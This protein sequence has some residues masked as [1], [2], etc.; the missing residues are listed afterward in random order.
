MSK[1]LQENLELLK[2]LK[3]A[4]A[5][6]RKVILQNANKSLILC[7]CECIKNILEGNV[8]LKPAEKKRLARH[9][10]ILR[11]VADRKLNTESK[12]K[13]LIQQGGF[14][15][16]LVAPILGIAGSLVADLVGRL[17]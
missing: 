13:L 4:K 11:Q 15:P 8:K 16:A 2:L 10:D 3:K 17:V 7:L 5:Q 6:D 12:R 1:R 14:I 9:A